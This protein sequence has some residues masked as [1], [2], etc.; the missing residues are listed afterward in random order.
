MGDRRVPRLH[1]SKR[2]FGTEPLFGPA[3]QDS[4]DHRRPREGWVYCWFGNLR[5]LAREWPCAREM[6]VSWSVY[7]T[8]W[9]G[10][11]RQLLTFTCDV[12]DRDHV[13]RM[14]AEVRQE[15]GEIDGPGQQCRDD[16]RGTV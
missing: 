13:E 5:G 6:A 15:L 7:E 16:C 8:N 14:I 12:T 1:S 11:G 10:L 4:V 3:G 2:N 9:P